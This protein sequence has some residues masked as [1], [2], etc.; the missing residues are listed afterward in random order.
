[1]NRLKEL[2][3]EH[4]DKQEDI[5][6]LLGVSTMTISR[7]EKDEELSI[8]HNQAKQLA[9]YFGVQVSY[10]LG[11][12]NFRTWSE[13]DFYHTTGYPIN[14]SD[15][16]TERVV[17]IDIPKNTLSDKEL[18]ALP[19]EERKAYIGEYL[20][21]M[22]KALSSLSDTIANTG[23]V[24]ADVTGE[25]LNRLTSSMLQALTNLNNIKTKD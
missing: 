4:G 14:L 17:K 1:M 16:P 25:Q 22:S 21:A 15:E 10:L 3:L 8:K 7:W 9:N 2:R 20:D 6:T 5:A 19:P 18:M 12:S 24:A 23:G 11:D 13:E